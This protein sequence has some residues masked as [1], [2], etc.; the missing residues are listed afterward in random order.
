[1][2]SVRIFSVDHYMSAPIL[3]LDTTYSQFRG[4][5]IKQV[6]ILR[7]FG[8]NDAGRNVLSH[9]MLVGLGTKSTLKACHLSLT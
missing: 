5:S 4:T 3:G 8:S 6:P 1:M 2:Y 7:I 9:G